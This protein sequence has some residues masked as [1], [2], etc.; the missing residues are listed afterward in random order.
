MDLAEPLPTWVDVH[1]LEQAVVSVL[2]N[3]HEHTS[4]TTHI[5]IRGWVVDNDVVVSVHDAGPGIL[6]EELETIFEHFYQLS[7]SDGGS[8]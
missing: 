6:D 7:L 8:G 3:A 5:T 2:A 4:P 1:R